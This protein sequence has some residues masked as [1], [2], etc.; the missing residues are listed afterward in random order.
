MNS[1]QRWLLAPQTHWLR[2]LLFQIHL[3]AAVSLGVY[4]LV[5]GLSG[6]ALLLKGPFYGWFEPKT[7]APSGTPLEGAALTARMEEVYAGYALG[8][9][10][11]GYRPG[12]ATYVVLNRDGDYFPHYF[13]Q[14]RGV[15]LGPANPWPIKAVE[16]VADLH[17]DLLLGRTGRQL[18]GAFALLFVFM[19]LSGLVLWWQGRARWYEGLIINPWGRRPL[20]W[21]LHSAFGFWALLLLLAWGI[22][23]FHLGHPAVLN[24]LVDWLDRDPQDFQRPDGLLRFLRG[25]HFA[26]YG[27]GPVLRWVWILLSFLPSLLLLSGLWLWLRR[28]LH[29]GARTA[30]PSAAGR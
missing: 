29:R 22:S 13:D 6:S 10:V 30:A 9:T 5:I 18:N 26:R 25:L 3:W 7:V 20:L 14:Y 2:R 28:L 24:G 4:V 19:A 16:W 15:D 21:Q 1:W 27:E 23:G 12:D 11:P 17:D 8:F